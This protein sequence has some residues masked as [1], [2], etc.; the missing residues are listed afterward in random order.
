MQRALGSIPGW[1][2]KIPH[3]IATWPKIHTYIHKNKPT[4]KSKLLKE[5]EKKKIRGLKYRQLFKELCLVGELRHRAV[6]SSNSSK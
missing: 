5:N 4:A 1:G 3:T 6:N 2:T